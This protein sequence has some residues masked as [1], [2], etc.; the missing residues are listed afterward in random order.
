MFVTIEA[1]RAIMS[2]RRPTPPPEC[3]PRI[4]YGHDAYREQ[5]PAQHRADRRPPTADRLFVGGE[6]SSGFG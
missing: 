1:M 5:A 6:K 2:E 4:L 3:H